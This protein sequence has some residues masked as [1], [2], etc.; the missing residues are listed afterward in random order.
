MISEDLNASTDPELLKQCA[1]FFVV[2]GQF[3]R[4]VDLLAVA[5][6]VRMNPPTIQ[7]T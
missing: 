4:A 3:D 1:R 5:K 6:K 7:T 2:N